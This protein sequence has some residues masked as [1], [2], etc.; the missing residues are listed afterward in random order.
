[1]L[2]AQ[3]NYFIWPFILLCI[4]N[5]L[6]MLNIWKRTRKMSRL[7]SIHSRKKNSS[8]QNR[9]SFPLKINSSNIVME[10]GKSL[11][12]CQETNTN[13]TSFIQQY[14]PIIQSKRQSIHYLDK[15]TKS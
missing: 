2:I 6:I 4:L 9:N 1:M 3:F 8:S 5:L 12:I 13:K 7:R 10:K 15:P 11:S 14:S